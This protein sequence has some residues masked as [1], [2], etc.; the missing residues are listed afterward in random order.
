VTC[1]G[2]ALEG[3]A[4]VDQGLSQRMAVGTLEDSDL[5][6]G[7]QAPV[8]EVLEDAA[9]ADHAVRSEFRGAQCA[10]ARGSE[11]L[12]ALGQEHQDLLV[13]HGKTLMPQPV[14]DEDAV[15]GGQVQPQRVAVPDRRV[16]DGFGQHCPYAG[17]GDGG[18]DEDVR[19]HRAASF[20]RGTVCRAV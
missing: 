6:V 20:G 1:G 12:D 16:Q 15:P 8:A 10:H 9:D 18:P 14:D 11:H 19:A 17:R 13:S 3:A 2:G 5:V 7:L 4:Q